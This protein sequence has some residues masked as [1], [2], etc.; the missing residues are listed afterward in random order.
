MPHEPR[1][2][3]TILAAILVFGVIAARH[4]PPRARAG[5]GDSN[6]PST[7]TDSGYAPDTNFQAFRTG[8]S[9]IDT[10]TRTIILATPAIQNQGRTTLYI[11]ARATA[12]AAT[13]SFQLAYVWRH[14]QASSD[15][16][17]TSRSFSWKSATWANPWPNQTY[18]VASNVIMGY[19]P[20]Y[21]ITAST[22]QSEGAYYKALIGDLP[23][24]GR[25]ATTTRILVTSA[26]SSGSYDFWLGS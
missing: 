3:V 26:P 5:N 23:I 1:Q 16:D 25:R 2:I 10:Q 18:T 6:P 15:T 12:N 7:A 17:V 24:D 4:D 11:G 22:V 20:I 19:S 9:A 21:T 8:I 14:P 13:V